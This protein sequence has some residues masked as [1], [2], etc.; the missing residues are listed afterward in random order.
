MLRLSGAASGLDSDIEHGM[1]ET[2]P[3]AGRARRLPG[4][5]LKQALH[6]VKRALDAIQ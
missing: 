2:D 4:V 5:E 3:Y 1:H 6:R